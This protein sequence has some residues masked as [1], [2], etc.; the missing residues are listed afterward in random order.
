MS[1]GRKK[2]VKVSGRYLAPSDA[3]RRS[4]AVPLVQSAVAGPSPTES[5]T[6]IS[7]GPQHRGPTVSPQSSLRSLSRPDSIGPRDEWAPS[8]NKSSSGEASVSRQT[9]EELKTLLRETSLHPPRDQ[10][11][12]GRPGS[13]YT[14][15]H[16]HRQ[17]AH[18]EREESLAKSF[19]TF[20]PLSEGS[21]RFSSRPGERT[22]SHPVSD[23]DS[24]TSTRTDG[25]ARHSMR[26]PTCES[27]S[28]GETYGSQ[29]G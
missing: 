8:Q 7:I 24:G 3:E 14:Y 4:A 17:D 5:P 15:L 13:P 2:G 22:S 26:S 29:T 16:G 11:D 18:Q 25:T 19:S 21:R 23:W 1:L 20:K 9:L 27:T 10:K 12:G 6:I 28:M